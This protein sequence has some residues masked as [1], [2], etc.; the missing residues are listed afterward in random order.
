MTVVKTATARFA[1]PLTMMTAPRPT[2][3]TVRFVPSCATM[4][5]PNHPTTA[6]TP[7]DSRAVARSHPTSHEVSF[8]RWERDVRALFCRA[9]FPL[10]PSNSTMGNENSQ[11]AIFEAMTNPKIATR[12]PAP[13]SAEV[14]SGGF[15][16]R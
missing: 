8:S 16:A 14:N 11:A 3:R 2:S 1:R 4:R 5:P 15:R 7:A 12:V 6:V 13:A 9:R 10:I